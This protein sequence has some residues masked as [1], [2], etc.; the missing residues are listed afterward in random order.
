[1]ADHSRKKPR[2]RQANRP[3]GF[4][5]FGLSQPLIEELTSQGIT[6]PFPIQSQSLPTSLS[7]RDVLGRGRT[8]S[9]KTLAFVLPIVAQLSRQRRKPARHRPRALVLA[10]TR[11]L[12]NQIN[13]V[14]EP[15]AEAVGLRST[16][17]YGGVSARPQLIALRRG[18]DIVVACPG[19]LLDHHRSGAVVFDDVITTVLDEADH[20]AD[21]GF[22]PDV[23]TI[24]D[25]LP[26]G[27]R[28]M[29]SATLDRDIDVIVKKY[30]TDPV[31]IDVDPAGSDPATHAD[32]HILQVKSGDRV[33]TIA[34]LAKASERTVI[35]TRTRHG[36]S[37]LAEKLSDLG[38]RSVDMH[39]ML[40][41]A[42]RARNL[43]RFHSGRATALVC[44]DVA[45]RGIHV[46]AVELVV[47]A[48]PPAESKAYLHRSG[49]TAR[50]G[51]RGTVVT[52][53]TGGQ[54]R[55]V[56][57][58][59]RRANVT[60]TESTMSAGQ[61]LVE[62][63]HLAVDSTSREPSESD[64][65]G[66]RTVPDRSRSADGQQPRRSRKGWA[67]AKPKSGHSRKRHTSAG[68]NGRATETSAQRRARRER[69]AQRN[70]AQ[71]NA[72]QRQVPAA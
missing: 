4:E 47:H 61:P 57:Q 24:L 59:T 19:R 1:M 41:Q 45:A 64:D 26:A 9:G 38:V 31:T 48:D 22:L 23:R 12:V 66:R 42:V 46:D 72:A 30:L 13:E 49:R 60:P 3:S 40:S 39:G 56:R 7:G 69:S 16:V 36:A 58:L 50:A 25:Q 53:A 51:A 11:E 55:S 21:L 37:K 62:Q 35:F 8:G 29:F 54:L 63:F 6:A 27:Q 67:K 33:E 52:I 5:E 17:I 70:A 10:P 20:M 14:I 28:M 2:H 43:E 18:V 71:R 65:A 68:R 34:A 15:L 32:H 44:T